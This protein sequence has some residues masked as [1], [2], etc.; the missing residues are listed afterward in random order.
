M[1]IINM[2]LL[3]KERCDGWMF[4][5]YSDKMLGME[6]KEGKNADYGWRITQQAS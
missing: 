2:F 6:R 3:I 1:A 4:V 5:K